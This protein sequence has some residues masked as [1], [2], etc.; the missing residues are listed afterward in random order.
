MPE[1]ET[2]ASSATLTDREALAALQQQ[3]IDL[4]TVNFNQFL[5]DLKDLLF[6]RAERAKPDSS[7]KNVYYDA[8]KAVEKHQQERSRSKHKIW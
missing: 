5:Q 4:L 6:K 1:N 7:G 2:N 3:S 8:M